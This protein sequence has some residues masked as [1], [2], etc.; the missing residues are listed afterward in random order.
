MTTTQSNFAPGR[1][2]DIDEAAA[3]IALSLTKGQR[4]EVIIFDFNT[5]KGA[6]LMHSS[7]GYTDEILRRLKLYVKVKGNT[8][9]GLVNRRKAEARNVF[10]KK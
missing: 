9:P 8:L 5:G 2:G 7:K 1:L 3:E 10:G 4:K 6:Y